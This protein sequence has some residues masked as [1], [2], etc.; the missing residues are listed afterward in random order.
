MENHVKYVTSLEKELSRISKVV[1]S[2][3]NDLDEL[4]ISFDQKVQNFSQ[5]DSRLEALVTCLLH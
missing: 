5:Q 4:Q 2:Q 1:K 3:Q